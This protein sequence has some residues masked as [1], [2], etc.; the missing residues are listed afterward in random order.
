MFECFNFCRFVMGVIIT[1]LS[2]LVMQW[3]PWISEQVMAKENNT[4]SFSLQWLDESNKGEPFSSSSCPATVRV[5]VWAKP[6]KNFAGII[7]AVWLMPPKTAK[8]N[9][10][11]KFVPIRYLVRLY[12]IVLQC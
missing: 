1:L 3:Y 5:P 6:H 12:M 11:Q 2:G 9:H 8:F 10:S 4:E 7:F